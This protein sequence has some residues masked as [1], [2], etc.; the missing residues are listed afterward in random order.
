ML[1]LWYL[2]FA[3]SLINILCTA[4]SSAQDKNNELSVHEILKL[5]ETNKN[6]SLAES[7]SD[8]S[9]AMAKLKEARSVLYHGSSK[10]GKWQL[11]SSALK[12][13]NGE[14]YWRSSSK[15][16][17]LNLEIQANHQ[18]LIEA[19]NLV[20]LE[21]MALFY[22]L[23]SSELELR[24]KNEIHALAYVKWNKSKEQLDIGKVSPVD[25]AKALMLVENTRLDYYR[26]RSRN[27]TFRIRLEE[28]INQAL[29]H[30][31]IFPPPPP[32]ITPVEV[33]IE[34]FS[35]F[36]LQR[37][38]EILALTKIAK[39]KGFQLSEINSTSRRIDPAGKFEQLCENFCGSK[40]HYIEPKE[41][42]LLLENRIMEAKRDLFA[43]E[44]RQAKAILMFKQRQVRLK[45][46][47]AIMD[48][49]N[50][51]QRIISAK[52]SFDFAQKKLLRSQQLYSL[53]RATSIGKAMIESTKAETELVQATGDYL[54]ELA[55]IAKLLGD[56][57]LKGLEKDYLFST[58]GLNTTQMES[59]IPKTGSGFG[60][61]D[62]NELNRNTQ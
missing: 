56:N 1:N 5:I 61:V 48:R 7:N 28:L 57:P 8:L 46:H 4:S 39:A 59:Y 17:A 2:I 36:V 37:N 60:Q 18:Y 54:L 21:G 10:D 29:P 50:A 31:L 6:Y 22:N 13:K 9:I 41:S 47:K 49:D 53:E 20:L 42:R 26:E 16:N 19:K 33:D 52:S 58:I 40:D 14:K 55:G 44:E 62:Q 24:A 27:N 3:L 25:V 43:A 35:Q 11:Q 51:Y 34:K 30:E 23:Y 32:T 45:A 15:V 12:N 38:P